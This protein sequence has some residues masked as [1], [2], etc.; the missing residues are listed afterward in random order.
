MNSTQYNLS[1][2]HRYVSI[3]LCACLLALPLISINGRLI[4]LAAADFFLPIVLLLG[5]WLPAGRSSRQVTPDVMTWQSAVPLV[6]WSSWIIVSAGIGLHFNIW[7][8]DTY[9][10]KKLFGVVVLLLYAL[11][12]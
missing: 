9:I 1:L 6:A 3:A 2:A 7:D 8:I 5:P 12:G 11:A 4:T 10:L